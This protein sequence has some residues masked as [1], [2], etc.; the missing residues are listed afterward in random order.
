MHPAVE[1]VHLEGLYCSGLG[2]F[3]IN[4]IG[5]LFGIRWYMTYNFYTITVDIQITVL[6]RLFIT[7]YIIWSDNHYFESFF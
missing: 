6:G 7:I 1:I 2:N 5:Y 4:V 3:V